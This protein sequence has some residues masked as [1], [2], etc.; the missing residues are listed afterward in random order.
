MSNLV[1]S[2]QGNG[3]TATSLLEEWSAKHSMKVDYTAS[4]EK[5]IFTC[6]CVV[7]AIGLEESG[8]GKTKWG[9]RLEAAHA[10]VLSLSGAGRL[11]FPP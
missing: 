7:A 3:E 2:G 11:P 6:K 10:A 1:A 4:E 8:H 5:G 9:A